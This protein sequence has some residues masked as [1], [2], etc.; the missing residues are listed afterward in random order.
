MSDKISMIVVM[1]GLATTAG[2]S[3]SFFARSGKQQPMSFE[4]VI[5]IKSE[6]EMTSDIIKV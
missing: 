2:S 6:S 5:V 1:N 4:I 3:L